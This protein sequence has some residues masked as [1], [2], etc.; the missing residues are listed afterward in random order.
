ML[1][2]EER[3]KH[4]GG[5]DMSVIMWEMRPKLRKKIHLFTEQ[6]PLALYHYIKNGIHSK[7]K[8]CMENGKTQ[9]DRIIDAYARDHNV[10]VDR[11]L[12]VVDKKEP[13]FAGNLDGQTRLEKKPVEGKTA[14]YRSWWGKA[15]TS[16]IPYNYRFQALQ[17]LSI[18][19]KDVCDIAVLFN[20]EEEPQY[21]YCEHQ[22]NTI[23]VMRESALEWWD[24]HITKN[25]PPEPI[26]DFDRKSFGGLIIAYA[27]K[28]ILEMHTELKKLKPLAQRYAALKADMKKWADSTFPNVK[29]RIQNPDETLL[30]NRV[31]SKKTSWD[32]D[33]MRKENIMIDKYTT[34]TPGWMFKVKEEK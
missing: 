30:A 16:Q 4:I 21:F 20:K 1:N 26:C 8:S 25:I 10:K 12:H 18:L 5:S 15:G 13:L 9:E 6:T 34:S 14:Y 27:P 19:E 23:R 11:H 24:K 32:E 3:R 31:P 17:Y 2:H 22:P 7:K 29:L 33:L 28:H